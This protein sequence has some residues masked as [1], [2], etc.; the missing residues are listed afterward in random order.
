MKKYIWFILL[1][2]FVS[3]YPNHV[4]EDEVIDVNETDSNPTDNWSFMDTMDIN[5][6]IS[7]IESSENIEGEHIGMEGRKSYIFSC[8]EKLLEV[9]SD[10][11]WVKLSYSKSPVMKYYA[12][13][14]L[15]SKENTNLQSVRDR[16]I[17]D[18]SQV[19]FHI[20]DRILCSPFNSFIEMDFRCR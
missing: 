14:A 12:Y 19:C 3:C 18:T 17:K 5:D 7:A 20:T 6:L 2:L 15:F 8:Y 11:L 13:K 9:A 1:L 16:L 10:S 4:E